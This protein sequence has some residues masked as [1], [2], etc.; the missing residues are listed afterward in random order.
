VIVL[1]LWMPIMDGWTFLAT[2]QP[3]VPVI[4]LSGVA[5]VRPLPPSVAAVLM[6]PVGVPQLINTI[7]KV[8]EAG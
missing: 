7:R 5:D 2:A 1:D 8:R 4:V 6:K 3:G